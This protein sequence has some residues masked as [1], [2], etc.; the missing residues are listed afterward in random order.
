M[1]P[2]AELVAKCGQRL[3]CPTPF[4]S[5]QVRGAFPFRSAPPPPARPPAAWGFLE[6][7]GDLALAWWKRLFFPGLSG[8]PLAAEEVPLWGLLGQTPRPFG[9]GPKVIARL[10]SDAG[11]RGRGHVSHWDR[12]RVRSARRAARCGMA[13]RGSR[14]R[15]GPGSPVST[16]P[17]GPLRR[18]SLMTVLARI[19]QAEKRRE[20]AAPEST[21]GLQE[22]GQ[23]SFIGPPHAVL[24]DGE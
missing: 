15:T 13:P 11:I 23:T 1:Q 2:T 16:A 22:T 17:S 21:R 10:R 4:G 19:A 3:S 8:L 5:R 6:P 9:A 7:M 20:R 18:S 24:I 14:H 12:G